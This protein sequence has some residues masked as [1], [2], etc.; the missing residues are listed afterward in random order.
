MILQVLRWENNLSSYEKNSVEATFATSFVQLDTEFPVVAN[1]LRILAFLD[2][3]SISIDI[4]VNGSQYLLLSPSVIPRS[5]DVKAATSKWRRVSI[6]QKIRKRR[7]RYESESVANT[8]AAP[9]VA[10]DSSEV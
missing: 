3:E 9:S 1:F 10:Y 7:N 8:I 4:I 2:P 6:M 5:P